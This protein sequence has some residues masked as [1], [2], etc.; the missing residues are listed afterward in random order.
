MLGEGGMGQVFLAEHTELKEPVAL[1]LLPKHLAEDPGFVNRFREEA[2]KLMKLSHTNIVQARHFDKEGDEFY[3]VME[4]VD[5]GDLTTLLEEH[6]DGVPVD[7]AKRMILDVAAA[8]K[9]AH[10]TTIH[11]DL[12]L[13]NILLTKTQAVKVSDFGLSEVVGEE[14]TR[15]LVKKSI[16]FSQVGFEET[17]TAQD[18]RKAS[19]IV[20]KVRYMSPQVHQGEPADRRND[21]Y[22]LGIII[23][24]L[25]TGRTSGMVRSIRKLKP[26]LDPA[27]QTVF[28]KCTAD[29]LEDRYQTVEELEA[30]VRRIG[31]VEAAPVAHGSKVNGLLVFLLVV[32]VAGVVY[33]NWDAI[34]PAAIKAYE[35]IVG[36]SAPKP[37]SAPQ[38]APIDPG[39]TQPLETTALEVKIS[40]PSLPEGM[41]LEVM[42][43]PE[44][45]QK[46]FDTSANFALPVLGDAS[47]DYIVR[48]SHDNYETATFTIPS[49]KGTHDIEFTPVQLRVVKTFNIGTEPQGAS[50]FVGEDTT[51]PV[52]I[53][54]LELP[55][56]FGRASGAEQFA[57]IQLNLTLEGFEAVAKTVYLDSP[58]EFAAIEMA[59]VNQFRSIKIM[60]PGNVELNLAYIAAGEFTAGSPEG[61]IGRVPASEKQRDVVIETPFYI[62]VTEITRRQYRALMGNDT[63]FYRRSLENP[64]EQI[65]FPDLTAPDGFLA[66]LT[67]HIRSSGYGGWEATLP[68]NDEWEYAARAGTETTFYN[69]ENI[70]KKS[71]DSALDEISVYLSTSRTPQPVASK[72]G[73]PWGLYDMLG[74]VMEWTAE[75]DLR[76]GSFMSPASVNRPAFRLSGMDSRRNASNNFRQ[77]GFRVVL[78]PPAQ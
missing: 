43:A 77:Y 54:P 69:G 33:S 63:N 7:D 42:N 46:I 49:R 61:E 39:K 35:S 23:Y 9:D 67:E 8:M 14:Y 2:R 30:A 60:L 57:P 31:A 72:L 11:R 66:K 47:E 13:N 17:I 76:G 5:G 59:P 19:N 73:N 68:T 28:E 15:S 40:A 18:S 37:A 52:G 71:T 10:R 22:A 21:I 20:G 62:G 38:P 6:P 36:K 70:T 26:E 41:S 3:L 75:G 16:T 51:T 12:S 58:D 4:Y 1:K 24:E 50:V 74:N 53:T 25:L 64:A 29:D 65:V 34:K 48:F 78:R 32:A 27:W 45:A 44:G 55:L 56:T